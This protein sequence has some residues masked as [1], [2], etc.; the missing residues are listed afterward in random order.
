MDYKDLSKIFRSEAVR[1]AKNLHI[2]QIITT[3]VLDS[4]VGE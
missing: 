3:F 4:K 2:S 1:R